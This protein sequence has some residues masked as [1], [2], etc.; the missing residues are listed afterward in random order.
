M[1]IK[2]YLEA[3]IVWFFTLILEIVRQ[4]IYGLK[5]T[6]QEAISAFCNQSPISKV[7]LVVQNSLV[8][9]LRVG[10][11]PDHVS[12]VMDGNRR[13]ANLKKLPLKEGHEAGGAT[14]LKLVY[15]CKR[16]GVKCISCYAFSIE[17]FNRSQEEIDTL[18]ELFSRKLS[19]FAEKAK[20]H[21]DALHGCKINVVG[22]KSLLSAKLRTQIKEVEKLTDTGNTK[23]SLYICFP[24]T[25]RDEITTS[26]MKNVAATRST[27]STTEI[28]EET[29]TN[30][31]HL[32]PFSNTCDILIRTSGHKRLSD[33]MLWESHE[34]ATIEFDNT[35][36]PSFGFTKIFFI[37]LKWSYYKNIQQ[38]SETSFS[39]RKEILRSC[40]NFVK[41]VSVPLQSLAAA[42]PAVT[43]TKKKA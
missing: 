12:F 21:Q 9:A 27:P 23:F 39:L 33:Y 25:S 8:Y 1:L 42:P 38:Y 29:L 22:N 26:I 20:D 13:F 17:N 32:G 6:M 10:P 24:Y 43:V 4:V 16:I 40:H 7:V 28:S 19:E 5:H 37:M 14:F 41:P 35:L 3:P 2:L 31:M 15:I 30:N 36:W 18:M 34:N 11:V